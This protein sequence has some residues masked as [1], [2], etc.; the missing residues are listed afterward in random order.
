[1]RSVLALSVALLCTSGAACGPKAEP[2]T[3]GQAQ[4]P[5]KVDE[6]AT[7]VGTWTTSTT[8]YDAAAKETAATRFSSDGVLVHGEWKN[9]GFAAIPHA[10][11]SG[12][13]F[14]SRWEIDPGTHTIRFALDGAEEQASYTI[15]GPDRFETHAGAGAEAVTVYYVRRLP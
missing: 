6:R 13:G 10:G 7:L 8:S 2:A 3:G 5:V 12:P 11:P 15:T 4:G 1:M 9:G 14:V